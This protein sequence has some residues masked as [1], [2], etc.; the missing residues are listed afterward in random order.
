MG[1]D[2]GAS[3]PAPFD[4]RALAQDE[5]KVPFRFVA[6]DGTTLEL[7]HPGDVD[8][9]TV[10]ALEEATPIEIMEQ[11]LGD[12]WPAFVASGTPM[13]K[14]EPLLNAWGK[15]AGINLGELEASPPSS[16]RTARRSRP[17]SRTTTTAGSR[18]SRRGG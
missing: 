7:P 13:R 6:E 14:I 3:A 12:D 11:L 16:N 9:G 15:H 1:A 2:N 17:T 8:I 18:T 4:L 5:T 10:V